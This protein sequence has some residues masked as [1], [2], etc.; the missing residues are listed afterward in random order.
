MK[1]HPLQATSVGAAATMT[2]TITLTII[3]LSS[4][5]KMSS[6]FHFQSSLLAPIRPRTNHQKMKMLVPLK[7]RSNI[8]PIQKHHIMTYNHKPTALSTSTTSHANDDGANNFIYT[9]LDD[10]DDETIFDSSTF[11]PT[12]RNLQHVLHTIERAA[13]TASKIA[14]ATSGQIAVQSTKANLRDLVTESDLRCQQIIKQIVLEEFPRDLFLGE[15]DVDLSGGGGGGDSSVSSSAALKAVLFGGTSSESI[16][17]SNE[18]EQQDEYEEEDRLVFIVDPIDGTTNFQAGLPIYAMS[19]G[20]VVLPSS[21]SSFSSPEVVAGVI[22]NPTLGEM[23]SAVRGRGCYLNNRRIQPP[24]S[25]SQSQSSQQQEQVHLPP[26]TSILN[27][28]LINVGFPISK[29]STLLASSKAVTALAV[30]SR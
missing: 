20:V 3:A 10:D 16:S 27:Q 15:E 24:Q 22:Y 12:S 4:V 17:D 1:T 28:S 19:I 25:Q 5:A 7:Q 14:L 18:D 30:P 2:L 11:A 29:E 8:D 26:R 23:T 9:T 6:A 21:S 13:Y